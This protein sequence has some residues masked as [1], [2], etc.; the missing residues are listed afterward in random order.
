MSGTVGNLTNVTFLEDLI[1]PQVLAGMINEKIV[2]YMRFAPLCTIDHTLQG[3]PGS[4]ITLPKWGYIGD[5]EVVPE[6]APIPIS[7]LSTSTKEVKIQKIGKGVSITDESLLSGYA[8]PIDRAAYE[9]AVSM[10]TKVD[11]DVLASCGEIGVNKTH[12]FT[13]ATATVDDVIKALTLFGEDLGG[14]MALLCSPKTYEVVRLAK[15]WCPASDISAS[16]LLRGAVGVVSGCQII[17]SNKLAATNTSYIIKPGAL[18]IFLKRDV[19]VEKDR[20]I[21]HDTTYITANKHYVSYLY[22]ESKALKLVKAV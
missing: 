11:N 7:A 9:I 12:T 19:Q 3:Q 20:D 17:V 4:T 21:L 1:D 6:G 15:D 5:A 2:D 22:D 16:I 14:S 13:G 10:A 8:N 18:R